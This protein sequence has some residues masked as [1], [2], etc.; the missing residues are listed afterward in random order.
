VGS[1]EDQIPSSSG[2]RRNGPYWRTQLNNPRLPDTA[3]STL[4][5][6]P[7]KIQFLRALGSGETD[8]I[9]NSI[10]YLEVELDHHTP[11]VPH[12]GF[13]GT[14]GLPETHTRY[15]IMHC[16][17]EL[18]IRIRSKRI[19]ESDRIIGN[20]PPMPETKTPG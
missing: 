1:L 11:M 18:M 10:G 12:P 9:L 5:S 14:Q 19:H 4:M 2:I 3:R 13:P 16:Y 6:D 15:S 20:P 17:K 8:P 7:P